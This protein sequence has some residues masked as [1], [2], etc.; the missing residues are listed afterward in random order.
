[1]ETI[2]QKT[3]QLR[4]RWEELHPPKPLAVEK[5]KPKP[6]TAYMTNLYGDEIDRYGNILKLKPATIKGEVPTLIKLLEDS[7]VQANLRKFV[8]SH[9]YER[10]MT[11]NNPYLKHLKDVEWIANI[12]VGIDKRTGLGEWWCVCPPVG[13]MISYVGDGA[14]ERA[15]KKANELK[16]YY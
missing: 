5:E 6:R 15:V 16:E 7:I 2:E 4:K 8:R 12:A 1:M 11:N 14:K 10:G 9:L 3:A 13:V